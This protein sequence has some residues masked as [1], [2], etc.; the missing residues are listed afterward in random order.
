MKTG[1]KKENYYD[2]YRFKSLF[3]ISPLRH[4]L[5]SLSERLF[6]SFQTHN[7]LNRINNQG[8]VEEILSL[9]Q[10]HFAKY[11]SFPIY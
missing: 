4:L 9:V 8:D 7:P 10:S 2:K 6:V 3:D 5:Q 1:I 11:L